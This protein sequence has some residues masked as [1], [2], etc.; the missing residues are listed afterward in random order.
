MPPVWTSRP[1]DEDARPRGRRRSAATAAATGGRLELGQERVAGGGQ[2][3]VRSRSACRRGRRYEARHQQSAAAERRHAAFH[4][5]E[6]PIAGICSRGPCPVAAI[7]FIASK[8]SRRAPGCGLGAAVVEPAAV[9]QPE[10]GVEA[11]EV[12]GAG[13]AVGAGGGLVD[14]VQVGKRQVVLAGEGAHLLVAVLR[15]GGRRRSSR[16][17]PRRSRARAAPC[18]R[19]PACRSPRGRRDSGCR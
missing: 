4:L 19:A 14:V 7:S 8:S 13:G 17:P 5:I 18:R 16:S 3:R 12:G 2:R 6:Q 9:L 1:L 11:E 10:L 15:R